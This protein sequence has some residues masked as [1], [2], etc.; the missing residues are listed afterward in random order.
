MDAPYL[1]LAAASEHR[2]IA[3]KWPTSAAAGAF[4]AIVLACLRWPQN[5]EAH[6]HLVGRNTKKAAFPA[7]STRDVHG[8]MGHVHLA[9]IGDSVDRITGPS[10]A[11][12]RG[13]WLRYTS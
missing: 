5:S 8:G 2:P 13:R 6:I 1:G 12:P 11:S 3:S 9:D 4:G 10:I 7:R